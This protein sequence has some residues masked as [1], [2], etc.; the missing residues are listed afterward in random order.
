MK[1]VFLLVACLPLLAACGKP[2]QAVSQVSGRSSVPVFE[3][4]GG[5]EFF[6]ADNSDR[7]QHLYVVSHDYAEIVDTGTVYGS[8]NVGIINQD[9]RTDHYIDLR[10]D[11]IS[12]VVAA[13]DKLKTWA[14]AQKEPARANFLV[15]GF[16]VYLSPMTNGSEVS[17]NIG[18]GGFVMSAKS[19]W[20]MRDAL[21]KASERVKSMPPL[22]R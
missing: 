1:K 3:A 20:L 13:I 7:W 18:G 8:V 21:L 19:L 12:D 15:H 11:E 4:K 6:V 16:G 22:P 14:N 10:R 2:K 5:E 9:L 17:V